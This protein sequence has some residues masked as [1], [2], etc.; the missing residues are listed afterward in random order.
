M[1]KILWLCSLVMALG[2]KT[3]MLIAQEVILE[4]PNLKV[5]ISYR[6]GGEVTSFLMKSKGI[7]LTFSDETSNLGMAKEQ[8]YG[9][10]KDEFIRHSFELVN[11]M[12]DSV[13]LQ[14]KGTTPPF[15][16]VKLTKTFTLLPN[17]LKIEAVF[18][19]TMPLAGTVKI[20]PWVHNVV[21]IDPTDKE[22]NVFFI[23]VKEG[24]HPTNWDFTRIQ[25]TVLPA[26]GNW[27]AYF[28]EA[29]RAGVFIVS[30][31]EPAFYYNWVGNK[32][33][34]TLEMLYP[35]IEPVPSYK[36]TYYIVPITSLDKREIQNS[37]LEITL[38]PSLPEQGAELKLVKR[39]TISFREL[40]G[41]YNQGQGGN[42]EVKHYTGRLYLSPDII[43]PTYF[44]FKSEPPDKKG[45]LPQ[46]IFEIPDKV[47]IAD[48]CAGYWWFEDEKME[49]LSKTPITRDG[50]PYIRYTFS[51]TA[52]MYNLLW[53]YHIRL[54]FST[55]EKDGR[56]NIYYWG[57]VNGKTSETNILPVE[58][59]R[60]PPIKTPKR[61]LVGLEGTDY[62][63]MKHYPD[64]AKNLRYLGFNAISLNYN[65][66]YI[67][68]NEVYKGKS[69]ITVEEVKNFLDQLRKEGFETSI[70]GAGYFR[71]PCEADPDLKAI[72][73]DGKQTDNFDFTNRGPWIKNDV[74]KLI[75]IGLQLGF[76]TIFSDYEP[77]DC[78][79]RISFTE[80]TVKMFY[81]YFKRNY[82][83]LEYVEPLEIAKNPGKYPKQE[84]IWIDFKCQQFADYINT[85]IKEVRKEYPKAK[86]GLNTYAEKSNMENKRQHL[87]DHRLLA[88][89][90]DFVAPM[91][92]DN[93]YK[94]MPSARTKFDWLAEEVAGKKARYL[95]TLDSGEWGWEN[96]PPEENKY[97]ILEAVTSGA[98]GYFL[99]HAFGGVDVLDLMYI[100]QA[101]NIISQVEDILYDG[102]RDDS[103]IKV[104]SATNLTWNLPVKIRPKAIE[105]KGEL[106]VYLADYGDDD[107]EV[108]LKPSTEGKKYRVIDLD[109]GKEVSKG[110]NWKVTLAGKERGKMFHLIPNER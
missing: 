76:D 49:L 74:V 35:E 110:G 7:D 95:P 97:I 33:I 64:S 89:I 108:E 93:V 84:Q 94:T 9:Q 104:V 61:F 105:Y 57:M 77:Y 85:V 23:S 88:D 71:P 90:L 18:E 28:N 8:I 62:I 1:K 55:R 98:K 73:I 65:I 52:K 20:I 99:W 6:Q 42:I 22:K 17:S 32:N 79:D 60:I 96:S 53:C 25:E 91:V 51:V 72:D 56:F 86:F 48:Y 46:V 100:S 41:F 40:A 63:L 36:I 29:K 66:G 39:K 69:F 101:N 4:N 67:L 26:E 37:G 87:E 12:K 78:G 13:I 58:I 81:E 38:S 31:P 107:I 16:R 19:N 83:G 3:G 75:E 21:R 30:S 106:V 92:Y 5:V 11:Q 14:T 10:N 80:R 54:F 43:A 59:V 2:L 102:K 50:Q 15:D 45:D 109:T 70:M 47:N 24:I 44:S 68:T 82:P 34:G 103:L 27:C